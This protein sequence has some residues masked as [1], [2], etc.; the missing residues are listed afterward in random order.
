MFLAASKSFTP[1]RANVCLAHDLAGWVYGSWMWALTAHFVDEADDPIA[2]GTLR[3][4]MTDF[5]IAP[6]NPVAGTNWVYD[7]F[8]IRA[9]G[10]M[11]HRPDTRTGLRWPGRIEKAE[12]FVKTGYPVG[13]TNTEWCSLTF[14]SEIEV[15]LDAWADWDPVNQE[16]LT[17]EDR[18]GSGGTI[19]KRKS[20]SYYPKDIFAVPLHDGSTLSMGDFILY[21]VLQFDRAKPDSAIYDESYVPEFD[22]FMETFKGVKFNTDDPDYGLIVEYY[23]DQWELDAELA[24]TTMFPIY[25]RGPGLWHSIALGIRAEEDDVLAFSQAK[26]DS[27]G[28]DWMS[29][30]DG[31]SLP[32][33][34]SYLDSAKAGSYIPYE[35]TMGLYVAEAQAAERWSN[36]EEWYSDKGHFWVA[37]GPFYLEEADTAGKVIHLKRFENYPDTMDRWLFLL[38][39]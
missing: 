24:V 34:E 4:A 14:Q 11:G 17:V 33:L 28:V 39:P 20:V 13:V 3:V 12:V 30:V 19:A 15:P 31:P 10:D 35:P 25:P 7:M 5:L 9:T 22:A 27:L 29:F 18:F 6:W 8:P 2:G 1:M 37:S 21:T 36:L 32:I 26:S 23:S 16:F 38:E